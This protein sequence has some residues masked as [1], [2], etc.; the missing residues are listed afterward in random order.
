MA[1]LQRY[2][3]LVASMALWTA[4]LVR[5]PTANGALD[6]YYTDHVRHGTVSWL[7]LSVGWRV[8]TDEYG[9]LLDAEAPAA[10]HRHWER[11][12]YLYP[13]G[14]LLLFAP[15][16][17]A[18][19][20]LGLPAQAVWLAGILLLL[21]LAHVATAL[22]ASEA[23]RLGPLA[24]GLLVPLV[25]L[26]LVHWSLN[27]FYDAALVALGLLAV[28]ALRT[29]DPARALLM[30][31]CA[32]FV[33]YRA[34]Y[35]GVLALVALGQVL[36]RVRSEP[37][38]RLALLVAGVLVAAG[39]ATLAVGVVN[40]G[41]IP[42]SNRMAFDRA[43]PT[44]R[45]LVFVL[46]TLAAAWAIR[47]QGQTLAAATLALV[48]AVLLN[49]RQTQSWHPLA[50]VPVLVL[51]GVWPRRDAGDAGAAFSAGVIVVWTALIMEPV[52]RGWGGAEWV[53]QA[54]KSA[55]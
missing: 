48:M 36:P 12:T 35:L 42:N 40:C 19:H 9:A 28:R 46:G 54:L 11:H 6:D 22:F 38:I 2:R 17:V 21:L 20:A 44:V 41:P 33:H 5:A 29:G 30:V 15:F 55:L 51:P 37:R 47:R 39:A 50:L 24:S 16:G 23:R 52:Y 14:A 53:V 7:A 18:E 1:F 4:V 10:A 45:T 32:F 49:T 43:G 34:V 3:L 25:Y 8:Y 27:G 26:E 31:A 13:P